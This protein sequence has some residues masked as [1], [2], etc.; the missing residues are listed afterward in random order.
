M[1]K[2]EAQGWQAYLARRYQGVAVVTVA[3]SAYDDS[4]YLIVRSWSQQHTITLPNYLAVC[5][6]IN[7]GG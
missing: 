2:S 7:R 6:L 3:R 1:I 4:Y 5:S